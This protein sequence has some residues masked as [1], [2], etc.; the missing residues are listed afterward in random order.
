MDWNVILT[1]TVVSGLVAGVTSILTSMFT[2]RFQRRKESLGVRLPRLQELHAK[3]LAVKRDE[4]SGLDSEL[5]QFRET[6]ELDAQAVQRMAESTRGAANAAYRLL[7][8]YGVY[9]GDHNRAE[10]ERAHAKAIHAH[11]EFLLAQ[12]AARAE[13]TEQT[14]LAIIETNAEYE[15]LCIEFIHFF[16]QTVER[17]ISSAKNF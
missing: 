2:L 3:L 4:M 15:R 7:E 1:S 17:E 10:V 16:K 9:L 12:R 11:D 14:G 6:Q 8:D 5:M 13:L